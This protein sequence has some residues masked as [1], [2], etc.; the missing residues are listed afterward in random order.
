MLETNKKKIKDSRTRYQPISLNYYLT[1]DKLVGI[2]GYCF[3]SYKWRVR[4]SMKG[5]NEGER[6]VQFACSKPC[7]GIRLTT[8]NK[9]DRAL[10]PL[11]LLI[12]LRKHLA[13]ESET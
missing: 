2:F 9:L 10:A 1:I 11:E 8:I 4:I 6:Q 7:L 12:W 3:S 5:H 13:R